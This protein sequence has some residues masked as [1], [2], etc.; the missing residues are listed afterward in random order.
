MKYLYLLAAAV[1]LIAVAP[2]RAQAA[3]PNP[4]TAPSVLTL[5]S[6]LPGDMALAD[7]RGN[8]GRNDRNQNR[9]G[10]RDDR[11]GW[12]RNGDQRRPP[13][14]ATFHWTPPWRWFL[15]LPLFQGDRRGH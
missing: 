3:P 8:R 14:R 5:K 6:D 11:R 10:N 2:T 9:N 1:I 12:Q 13:Q 4:P 7:G 15:N